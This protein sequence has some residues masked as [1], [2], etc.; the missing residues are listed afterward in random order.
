MSQVFLMTLHPKRVLPCCIVLVSGRDV[1]RIWGGI[2]LGL[3][4]PELIAQVWLR[5][6]E[7]IL[8]LWVERRRCQLEGWWSSLEVAL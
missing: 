3:M 6:V 5:A 7:W 2:P 4:Q 8:Q 1:E